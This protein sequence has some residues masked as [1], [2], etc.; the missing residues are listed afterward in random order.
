MTH[1]PNCG[2]WSC[3]QPKEVRAAQQPT[4]S[5]QPAHKICFNC[6]GSEIA[7]RVPLCADCYE[8]LKHVE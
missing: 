4:A 5:E 3:N 8:E 6:G 1:M 2:C 7:K